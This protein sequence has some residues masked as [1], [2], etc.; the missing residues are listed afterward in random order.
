MVSLSMNVPIRYG[1]YAAGV[2]EA[3]ARYQAAVHARAQRENDLTSGLQRALFEHR[4][5]QR[6]IDLYREV[7]IPKARESIGSIETAFRAGSASFLD[8]VDAE[9]TLL[10][11]ELSYERAL[12]NRAQRLA[13]IE[14]AVGR[15]MPLDAPTDANPT[16][17]QEGSN[18]P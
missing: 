7:L 17:P 14:M 6:K 13:R 16:Q 15:A 10:D 18:N 3:R 1:K 4:D 12:A 11:F 9:R 2:R 5:A 8:L